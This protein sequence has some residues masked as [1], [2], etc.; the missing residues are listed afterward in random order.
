MGKTERQRPFG[1]TRRRWDSNPK[2]DLKEIGWTSMDFVNF[3][4][5]GEKFQAVKNTVRK[6]LVS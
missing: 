6:L 1:G 3:A 2:L 5:T 4:Q